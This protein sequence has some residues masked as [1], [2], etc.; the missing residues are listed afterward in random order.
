MVKS[1]VGVLPLMPA[2]VGARMVR[3][4]HGDE[5]AVDFARRLDF[6]PRHHPRGKGKG[7]LRL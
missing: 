1:Q 5:V 7:R 3:F 6:R 2:R 4:H